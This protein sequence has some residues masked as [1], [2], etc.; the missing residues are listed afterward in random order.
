MKPKVAE[1]ERK[2]EKSDTEKERKLENKGKQRECLGI[3][4]SNSWFHLLNWAL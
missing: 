1:E 4:T 2:V 3:S